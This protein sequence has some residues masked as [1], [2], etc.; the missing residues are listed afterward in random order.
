MPN[1]KISDFPLAPSVNAD[2]VLPIVQLDGAVL[3]D[4]KS[5][6]DTFT[7]AMQSRLTVPTYIKTWNAFSN[8]PTLSSGATTAG[9]FYVVGIAGST[10]LDGETNWSVG[11]YAYNNG[12]VWSKI[13][14]NDPSIT[15]T[16]VTNWFGSISSTAGNIQYVKTGRSVTLQF[17][18]VSAFSNITSVISAETKLPSFL[19]PLNS[20][21]NV[22]SAIVN[23]VEN[24]G[25]VN[26]LAGDGT[27]NWLA[28]AAGIQFLGG[29]INGFQTQTIT[30]ISGS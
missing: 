22:Q 24:I 29:E 13:T 2:A 1:S 10:N 28:T 16:H 9:T 11:D 14:A 19:W 27:I 26:I 21:L 15:G 6:L 25:K 23:G 8:T 12:S 3:I 30:Y 7:A 17:S 5:D 18:L 20:I 4:Y